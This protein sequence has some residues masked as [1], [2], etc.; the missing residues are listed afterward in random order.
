MGVGAS[1]RLSAV[2]WALAKN[3]VWAWVLTIPVTAVLGAIII[4]IIKTLLKI[5]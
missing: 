5:I 3:I 4:L 1:K 2:R